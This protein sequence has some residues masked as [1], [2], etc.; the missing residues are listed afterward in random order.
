M[1]TTRRELLT[2]MAASAA[3]AWPLGVAGQHDDPAVARIKAFYDSLQAA[4]A[5]AQAAD[6]KQRLGVVSEAM[7]RTFDLAAMTRLAVGAQWSK[8][9]AAKQ[10]SLQEAFGRYFIASYASRLGGAAG[11]RFDVL[12]KS[13][14]RTG[15]RL[16]RTRV[17][18]AGGNTTPV[19]FLLNADGRVVDVYLGGTVSE[20]ASRRSEFDAALKRGGPD[21]LEANLRKRA[22]ELMDGK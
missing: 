10:A 18:D 5:G 3:M 16:V 21:A 20:L 17:T 22:D 14:Q 11:G 8:I 19:D 12:P 7:M 9:P 2:A 6:P 13:E 4:T 1:M 15:G